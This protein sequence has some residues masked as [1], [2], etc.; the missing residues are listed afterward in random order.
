MEI[1]VATDGAGGLDA[2]AATDFGRGE[3]F[4]FVTAAEGEISAVRVVENAGHRVAEGAGIV[5]AEQVARE[6]VEVAA[7]GHFGPHA[8]EILGEEGVVIALVPK[9]T[10][11]EAVERVLA[12]LDDE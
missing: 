5:A 9:V 2:V 4:T 8:Q 7:A 1:V 3:T 10:V 11:R 12:R 6:G